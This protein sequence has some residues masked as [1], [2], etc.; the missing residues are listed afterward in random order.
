MKKK[1]TV[2]ALCSVVLLSG[3]GIDRNMPGGDRDA[4]GCLG[5][6]GYTWCA[7]IQQC[8]RPGE[9]IEQMGL[10]DSYEAYLDYCS[11][12]SEEP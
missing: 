4:N 8:A 11:P 6:G 10:E 9:I 7:R 3:C 2:I 12:A 5:S 1:K